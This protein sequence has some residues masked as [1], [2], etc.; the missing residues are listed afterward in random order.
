MAVEKEERLKKYNFKPHWVEVSANQMVMTDFPEPINHYRLVNESFQISMEETYFWILDYIRDGVGFAII[1]KITDTLTASEY[2]AFGGVAQQRISMQQ[3]K[4]SQF[5][6]SIAKLVKELFQL[7]RELRILDERIKHYVDSSDRSNPNFED[8][9]VTLKGT[10][11]DMVEGGAKNPSSVYGM[12]R[13]VQF[14]TLPDLFFMT[15]V[16]RSEEIPGVIN[17]LK[18]NRKVREVLRR[19]LYGFM[20]WKEMTEKELATRRKFTLQY[21]RQ[22]F[23]VILMYMNWVKP[24]L[25]NIKRM[26][27]DER[28]SDMPDIVSA[29]EGAM[30]ETEFLALSKPKGNKTYYSVV[31][32][33]ILYRIRPTLSYNQEHYQ[34][35]PIHV[36]RAEISFRSYA[37]T[38]KQIE[39]YRK[40]RD[41]EVY[42]LIGMIDKNIKDAMDYLGDELKGYLAQAGEPSYF[43]K[44]FSQPEKPKKK[45]SEFGSIFSGFSELFGSLIPVKSEK[46]PEKTSRKE[47]YKQGKEKGT[48]DKW[49][50][51]AMWY[52][53][54]NYK[55]AHRLVTW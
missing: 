54:K 47:A 34:R 38:D 20:K 13:E 27:M 32:I 16:I 53:Y 9:N 8:A 26:Q 39:S 35:G 11:I 40:Y 3:E 43:D 45:P 24:Y 46:R 23:D 37:W 51:Q 41:D 2:S 25:K 52:T 17:E 49:A 7:V 12:A 31:D 44:K 55:K 15:N 48:A 36:G 10:F 18:F 5:M 42:D 30:I 14:T 21:L 28:K 4:V 33:H 6:H 1:H 50:R 19:K 29:F 22:H